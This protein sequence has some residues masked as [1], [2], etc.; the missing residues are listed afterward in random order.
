M[1]VEY[2]LT[3]PTSIHAP[4][5][6]AA[7]AVL[8]LY[9]L[10][11]LLMGVTYFRLIYTVVTNPGYVERSAQWYSQQDD[12]RKQNKRPSRSSHGHAE[13]EKRS[14][15]N[16]SLAGY[17]H[18]GPDASSNTL[19]GEQRPGLHDFFSRDVF[20]C[21]GD[22]RPIWC[23]HCQNWKP[24]RAHHCREV[25][26]CVRKMDHYCPW[27]GGVVSETTFKFFVQFVGWTAIYCF[28][29]LITMAILVAEHVRIA[30]TVN[31]HWVVTLA[32]GVLFGLFTA[33]MTA[34]SLQFAL[35]N[36]NTIENLSRKNVVYQVA[37][38]MP[39][40]PQ[41]P[42][43][44]PTISYS[45]AQKRE[46]SESLPDEA[47]RTFAILH[48]K[49]GDSP[50]DVG[51]LANF[52][53]VMGEHW[54]DWFLPIKYSPCCNHDR[55]DSQFAMGP[56]VDRMRREAGILPPVVE[57]K[58]HR[59]RRHRR[60]HRRIREEVIPADATSGDTNEKGEDNGCIRDTRHDRED[61]TSRD[62]HSNAHMDTHE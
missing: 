7:I 23:T 60:R 26:R 22:G 25:D 37:V 29:N 5:H 11:L 19:T 17:A 46:S 59:S 41:A 34:S 4:R 62:E 44:F 12:K 38:Y 24:D 45:T 33:G 55:Y 28:F 43:R 13:S 39:R 10:L 56:V 3:P 20:I 54:Y 49:P 15:A 8:V 35:V 30:G 47:I 61:G 51:A 53:E 21:Q 52:K 2:L 1:L 14:E 36:T 9:F 32:F 27:V 31:V 57:E 40:P 50:W 18:T 16:G 6:G 58:P 42:P 48:S